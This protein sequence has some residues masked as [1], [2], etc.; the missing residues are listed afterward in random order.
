MPQEFKYVR[1]QGKELARNTMFAK[2]V[3]SMCWQLIQD[4]VMDEEDRELYKEIDGWFAEHLPWPEPCKNQEAVVCWFKTENADEMMRM[5]RPAMW[6]L[7]K[8]DHPYYVVYT[9]TPGEIVYEDQYQ[10][11]TKTDGRLIIQ[12]L[13][14]SWSPEE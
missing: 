3:F 6:L 7:E 2:G 11:A 9:N 10:I 14:E 4:D 1:I 8:Y 5:I 13:Q 12:E